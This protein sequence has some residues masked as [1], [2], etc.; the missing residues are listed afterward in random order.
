MWLIKYERPECKLLNWVGAWIQVFLLA[1]GLDLGVG[2]GVLLFTIRVLRLFA[3]PSEEGG[4]KIH[5][6]HS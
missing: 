6:F 4:T 2:K 1:G 3:S 5:Y